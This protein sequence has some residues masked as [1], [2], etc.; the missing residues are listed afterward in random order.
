MQVEVPS[1]KYDA[2]VKAMEN[3]IKKGEVPGITDPKKIVQKGYFTYQQARNIAK[4]G[5]VESITFDVVN[6][7]VIATCTFGISTVLSFATSIWKGEDFDVAIK[8]ATYTGLKGGGASANRKNYMV[9]V[10][11]CGIDFC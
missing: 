4:A 3:R 6:G 2:A 11:F 7:A 8:N 1:D 10:I 9:L 5:T